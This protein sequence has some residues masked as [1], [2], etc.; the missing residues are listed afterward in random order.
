MSK[1]FAFEVPGKSVQQGSMR[2][3]GK[4]RPMIHENE[5]ELQAWRQN[6]GWHAMAARPKHWPL[7]GA[8]EVW[9]TFYLPKGKTVKREFHTVPPDVDKLARSF[10][11]AVTSVLWAND[12]Q[13]VR[14]HL[15]KEYGPARL[16]AEVVVL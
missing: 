9:L 7:S 15:A 10:L 1:A 5:A 6:C 4:G 14:L 16:K 8:Y 3:L 2:N 13:V 12:A 11:D